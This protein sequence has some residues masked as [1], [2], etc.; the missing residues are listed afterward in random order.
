MQERIEN[1]IKQPFGADLLT[2]TPGQA[3]AFGN[4]ACIQ[5]TETGQ[6]DDQ[7]ISTYPVE[8]PLPKPL[9]SRIED[10]LSLN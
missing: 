8:S 7:I 2:V 9:G 3:V 1:N 6:T 4:L 5:A 10:I